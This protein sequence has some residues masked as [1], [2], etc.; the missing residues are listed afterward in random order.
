MLETITPEIHK[1]LEEIGFEEDEINAIKIIHELK[2]G[3]YPVDIQ[4]LINKVMAEKIRE[5]L[6]GKV[7]ELSWEMGK[8]K[9][10]SREELYDR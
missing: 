4:E 9:F 6:L 1:K 8:R 2:I 3:N 10:I 5:E 7:E